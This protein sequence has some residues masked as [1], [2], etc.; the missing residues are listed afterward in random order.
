MVNALIVTAKCYRTCSVII[1]Y[2]L[3]ILWY[4]GSTKSCINKSN[5][6]LKGS[7]IML[8]PDNLL[9]IRH[10]NRSFVILSSTA[11]SPV[12]GGRNERELKR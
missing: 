9:S 10:V 7:S 8:A 12:E 6:S 1:Y 11:V 5:T 4:Q 3:L 2:T